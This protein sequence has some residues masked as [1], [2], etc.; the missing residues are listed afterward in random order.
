MLSGVRTTISGRPGCPGRA[1]CPHRCNQRG[2]HVCC[3]PVAFCV[4][5]AA[6]LRAARQAVPRRGVLL[7]PGPRSRYAA[8]HCRGAVV[9]ARPAPPAHSPVDTAAAAISLR[10]DAGGQATS[11]CVAGNGA[12]GQASPSSGPQTRSSDQRSTNVAT[13]RPASRARWTSPAGRSRMTSG[14]S[15]PHVLARV[16]GPAVPA[17]IEEGRPGLHVLRRSAGLQR[18][19]NLDS[20][21]AR[22][23]PGG[24]HGGH[25]ELGVKFAADTIWLG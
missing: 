10:P 2:Q 23:L 24:G 3:P 8:A 17:D 14:K 13:G 16:P 22:F 12:G 5:P 11:G 19:T 20:G 21:H 6:R 25:G 7:V 4:R 9:E 15:R 1:A 18:R